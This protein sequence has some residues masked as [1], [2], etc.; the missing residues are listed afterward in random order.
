[1]LL[2]KA[3][4]ALLISR[5][6]FIALSGSKLAELREVCELLDTDMHWGNNLEIK[7]NILLTT[8]RTYKAP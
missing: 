3:S 4:V 1:M 5:Y 6:Q 8:K 7:E 2:S